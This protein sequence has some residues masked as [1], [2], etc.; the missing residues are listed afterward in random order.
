VRHALG[1]GKLISEWHPT[2]TRLIAQTTAVDKAL[3]FREAACHLN[4]EGNVM[5]RSLSALA[6]IF[7]GGLVAM[8]PSVSEANDTFTFPLGV[9]GGAQGCL[10]EANGTVNLNSLGIVE[11]MHI[12]VHFLPPNTDFD[13]FV[14]Q[15][16]NAPFGLAWYEGDLLTDANGNGITDLIG[17]F[18]FGTFIVAPGSTSAPVTQT[19]GPFPDQPKNLGKEGPVQLYHVGIWFDSAQVALKL[20]CTS[21]L[22]VTPF[23]SGHQAGIQVLNSGSAAVGPLGHFKP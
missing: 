14:I 8:A 9:S 6:I 11:E 4:R 10:P 13:V 16:S 20:G 23:N 2:A 21:K 17:R 15:Q 1:E 22:V 18:S 7:A 19:K 12:V 5:K 3:A